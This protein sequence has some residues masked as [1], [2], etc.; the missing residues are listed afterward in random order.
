MPETPVRVARCF[1]SSSFSVHALTTPVLRIHHARSPFQ[2][3]FGGKKGRY[4]MSS[5]TDSGTTAVP[6]GVGRLRAILPAAASR[7]YALDR[8]RVGHKPE[9]SQ[10]SQKQEL[11]HLIDSATNNHQRIVRIRF[12]DDLAMPS[13]DGDAW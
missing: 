11:G 12:Q 5:D 2:C 1:S 3:F 7:L 8:S 6:D 10:W 4:T 13:Y 9:P